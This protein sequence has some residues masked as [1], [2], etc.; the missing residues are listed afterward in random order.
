[1]KKKLRVGAI[2]KRALVVTFLV[3]TILVVL[4]AK[5]AFIQIVNAEKIINKASHLSLRKVEIPSRRG[6]ILDRNGSRLAITVEA[7][8]VVADPLQIENKEKAARE[9][10]K[11]LGID[12]KEILKKLNT[13]RRYVCIA[14]EVPLEVAI[15]VTRKNLGLVYLE[16]DYKRIYPYG[17]LASHV[18]GFVSKNE[19]AKT[20]Q[21]MGGEGL[22]YTYNKLLAGKPGYLIAQLDARKNVIPGTVKEKVPAADVLNLVITIDKEIQYF[23]EKKLQECIEKQK[24]KSG[25][26]IIMNPKNGEILAMASYPGYDLNKFNKVKDM[27]V[28]MNRA[29]RFQYEPGSTIKAIT[30]AAAI[31]EGI[32]APDSKIYLPEKL[33]IG[34]Y[35]IGE[36]H[37]RK[38]GIY[39]VEEIL[40]HSYNVGAVKLAQM[41]GPNKLYSYLVSF[42]LSR[43]T[44]IDLNGEQDGYV[45]PLGTWS[46][47]TIANLPFGQGLSA[48]PLQILRAFSV[49]ANDGIMV[50]PHLLMYSYNAENGTKCYFTSPLGEKVI[51]KQTAEVMTK[52][53][54]KVVAEGAGRLAKIPGYSTA[55][56]TGTAQ[57]PNPK[58]KGYLK[59]HYVASF[60]G[61]AP[62]SDPAIAMIVVI[63]D[64][65]KEHYG[66]QVAAPL[67]REIGQFALKQLRI[68]PDE[69]G[70]DFG[71]MSGEESTN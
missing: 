45:P 42:G 40:T 27:N 17:S 12:K 37:H 23:A 31:E 46:K 32:V 69:T 7:R 8:K 66:G 21:D 38:A 63:E 11:I 67:F 4:S 43:K 6:E 15:K 55:G 53:L 25:S 61:F 18:I 20:G 47:T 2:E 64:P 36:A 26:V 49:F 1:M 9:L 19:D 10:S 56:K 29:I 58:G 68:L 5:V 50:Q 59:G 24:A 62:V 28:M 44:G 70:S 41:L 16:R 57:I 35:K 3:I 14:R 13:N 33:E 51:S 48:T 60:V 71:K 52:L 54:E 22:E 39:T 30:V 65:K 34:S